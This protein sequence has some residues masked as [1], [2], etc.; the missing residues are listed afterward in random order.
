[1]QKINNNR[2]VF[3]YDVQ[4]IILKVFLIFAGAVIVFLKP[5]SYYLIF[6]L[7]CAL[8]FIMVF[9]LLLK[10]KTFEYENTTQFITIKQSYFWKLNRNV[11][12]IEFPNKKLVG[13][14][15]SEILFHKSLML[16]I[17]SKNQKT[18]KIYRKISGLSRSTSKCNRI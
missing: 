14:G 15:V 8:K 9:Y 2:T 13:L 4:L 17:Q 1:M 10:V 11:P 6:S 5:I 7:V 3:F 18:K 12:P 16:L